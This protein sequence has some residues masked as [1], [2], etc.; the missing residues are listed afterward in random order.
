MEKV[1]RQTIHWSI[2]EWVFSKDERDA[3]SKTL[4]AT[5]GPESVKEF[6][7]HLQLICDIKRQF[8]DHP[9]SREIFEKRGQILKDCKAALKHLRKIERGRTVITGP[10]NLETCGTGHPQTDHEVD[11]IL[12]TLQAAWAAVGPLQNFV[13]I[14]EKYHKENGPVIGRKPADFDNFVKRIAEI[15]Q[16]HIGT[17]T[18]YKDGPFFEIVRISLAAVGPAIEDPSR[19]IRRALKLVVKK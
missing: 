5:A 10:I 2:E 6:T 18:G 19:A 7:S 11:F 4:A 16:K 13:K 1:S 15:Y 8:F 12:S 17:P 9:S 3:I 14:L